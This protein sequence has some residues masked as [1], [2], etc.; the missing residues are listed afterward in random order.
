ML[1]T[2]VSCFLLIALVGCGQKG[3]LYLPQQV[4]P[5]PSASPS[6]ATMDVS[7]KAEQA[8]SKKEQDTN[9]NTKPHM[10]RSSIESER[11]P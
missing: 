11:Q 6:A 8:E 3:P 5:Q 2:I 1:K 7:S 4:P 10:P 9:Q